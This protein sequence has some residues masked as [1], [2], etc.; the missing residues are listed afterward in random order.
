MALITLIRRGHTA[1]SRR[2]KPCWP[3]LGIFGA[4]LFLG[5][6]MITPAISVLSAVEGLKVAAPSLEHLV[7][8]ITAAI[9]VALFLV[10]RIGTA[11]VGRLF[12]PVMVVWF[13]DHRGVRHQRDRRA[14]G[15]PQGAVADLRAGLLLQ[16]LRDRVL[17]AGRRRPR[18]HRRGGAVRGHGPLRARADHP[19]LAA[20]RVP[21]LHPELHGPGRADP[22]RPA[23]TSA[24]RSSCSCP[25]GRSGRWSSWPPRRRSSRRRRSSPAPSPSP[26]QAV[27][28]GYLPRLRIAHT[29]ADTIGQ[30][31]VPW[32]NWLLMVS[33]L[34]L[35]FA[36]Q[37]SA[38]LAFAFG[39]AVTG[40]ITI[41]TLLFFYI[42]RH[43][44]RKPLWLVAARR[45]RL[46]DRRPALPRR[47]PDQARARRLAAA[48]DRRD[49]LHH[50][51]H[52]A[53]RPRDRHAPARAR[54][55]LAARLHRRPPRA[56]AARSRASRAP[57]CS[58][59]APRSPRRW[60]CAP[61]SST[62]T[63]ST[64]TS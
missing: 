59:T 61:A 22:R 46:L 58:S 38:A 55:G 3:A 36:F 56:N 24:A 53:A 29:S 9:I 49:R 42:A 43:Q 47:E 4:S 20:A 23:R 18:G 35:V 60:P 21:R 17:R 44:W 13:L 45:R 19:R 28:L 50:A 40:T 51:D 52:L 26:H 63:R 64:S 5:D 39:M 6:S 16:P 10:Q 48:A 57:P 62:S 8:P 25:T 15:D 12:G 30:I 54:R 1:G 31:Y 33:V 27:Q 11:G 37:T 2:T 34:T 7:V 41:T 32:I 14:P